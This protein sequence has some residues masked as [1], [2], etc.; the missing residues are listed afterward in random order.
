[1][2]VDGLLWL[3][4]VFSG[5][6]VGAGLYEMRVNVPRWFGDAVDSTRRVNVDAI[7][8]D[9]SGRRFW[10]YVTTGPL[11]LLTLASCL[12]AWSPASIRERWLLVAAGVM[13]I[14]R[15]ATFG[16][17]IPQLLLVMKAADPAGEHT[18]QR[19]LTWTRLN[20]VRA[21]LASAAWLAALR[22]LSLSE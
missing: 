8:S 22:A 5:I 14:E 11:T 4:V 15:V 16:Y 3:F 13:L 21:A 20:Y 17:F 10:A 1:V 7:R 2:V 19:A 18:V 12:T 6:A 9:D